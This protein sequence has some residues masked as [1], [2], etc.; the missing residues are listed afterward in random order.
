[1]GCALLLIFGAA[2]VFGVGRCANCDFAKSEAEKHVGG[3]IAW[4]TKGQLEPGA[5]YEFICPRDGAPGDVVGS[6]Y[7]DADESSVCTAAVHA[8]L[9]TLREGGKVT[10]DVQEKRGLLLGGSDRNGVLA[11]DSRLTAERKEHFAKGDAG[12]PGWTDKVFTVVGA[13][14]PRPETS[15][16]PAPSSGSAA[17]PPRRPGALRDQ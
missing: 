8:G 2:M 16:R 4:G 13:A 6:D 10:I 9:I 17:P 15:A 3:E 14:P 7:Y 5:R 1:M 12:P 11:A